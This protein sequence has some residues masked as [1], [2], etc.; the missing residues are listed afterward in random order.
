MSSEYDCISNP[1]NILDAKVV[2]YDRSVTWASESQSCYRPFAVV[3][4]AL[5][6][7]QLFSGFLF[8]GQH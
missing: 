6:V 5:V 8:C 7:S 2:K 1:N 4:V 3:A